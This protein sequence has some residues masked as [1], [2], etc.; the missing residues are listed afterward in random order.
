MTEI[1]LSLR[2]K[3]YIEQRLTHSE[4]AS[5]L[6]LSTT[7]YSRLKFVVHVA[8][9]SGRNQGIKDLALRLLSD[10]ESGNTTIHKA[11]ESIK[12]AVGSRGPR[13]STAKR[14][15]TMIIKTPNNEVVDK[16]LNGLEGL[17]Y[18]LELVHDKPDVAITQERI[19]Q[20]KNCR[21]QIE[22]IINKWRTNVQ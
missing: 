14:S 9:F 8:Y 11:Y 22:S 3:D 18:G 17:T 19:E 6:N 10:V 15:F 7:N 4:G 1:T 16:A 21:R 13:P 5:K 20:L 2:I 12:A